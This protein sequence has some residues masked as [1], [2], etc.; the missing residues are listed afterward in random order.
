MPED[1]DMNNRTTEVVGGDLEDRGNTRTDFEPHPDSVAH[2]NN[3]KTF[4][5]CRMVVEVFFDI[6]REDLDKLSEQCGRKFFQ[7]QDYL[8]FYKENLERGEYDLGDL[9]NHRLATGRIRYEAAR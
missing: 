5:Q 7:P 4:G 9:V 1:F 6:P 3:K 2:P 8:R